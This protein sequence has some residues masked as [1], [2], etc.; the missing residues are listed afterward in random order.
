MNISS[1]GE[2][3]FLLGRV[4]NGIVKPLGTC[5]LLNKPGHFATAAHVINGS[6]E[7]LILVG[8][9]NVVDGYQDVIEKNIRF[10]PLK[11]KK[12]D[13]LR[14]IC[15]LMGN[16]DAVFPMSVL[17][18]DII[19]PGE[20][21]T[22]FGFPHADQGRVVLT[23]QTTEIGA[24][25]LLKSGFIKSKHIVLNIQAR[26]GQSGGPIFR[27]SD[28]SLIGILIGAYAPKVSGG[29]RMGGIDPQTLHQ[30][31]HAVSTEYLEGMLRE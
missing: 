26:P 6:D 11:I 8:R 1:I 19:G 18:T 16:T 14:D 23:Q 7:N 24:K 20:K 10:L 29:I 28:F 4:E 3:V 22:I 12:I 31:T 13:P 15:I 25:V 2:M 27:N 9:N 5:F 21:V 30:T 17:N